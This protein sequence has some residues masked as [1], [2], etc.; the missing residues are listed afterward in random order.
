MRQQRNRTRGNGEGCIINLGSKRKN[1]W[2]ARVTVGYDKNGKQK[3]KY[4]GYYRT[5]TD[6]KKA[7]ANYLINPYNLEKLTTQDIFEK[8]V[9]TAK[10]TE[11][12]LKNYK[13]VIDKS[14][15]AKKVFKDI[16][17]MQLEEAA[18]EL[19]PA[20]QKRYRS[21]WKHL[22][23]YGMRHDLVNKNLADLIQI[24]KYVANKREAISPSNVK[25]ILSGDND[26]AKVLLYTGMR[27]GEL[28]DIKSKNV[29][30]ENRIMVGGLKTESGKNRRIPLSIEILPIIKKWLSSN[31]E[32][33]VTDE[34]GKKVNYNNYLTKVWHKDATLTKYSPHYTR[35]TWIS[36]A[37]KLELNQVIIKAIVGHSSSDVTSGVYTHIDD[38]QLLQTIDAFSY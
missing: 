10:F 23:E 7:L 17:L 9:E 20:M 36:R 34:K 25:K 8:W 16:S 33:L 15:L 5:K 12:V 32:Y 28:L 24:D 31:K 3:F 19:T 29:D 27:I 30:I 14:G 1:P 26:I 21:A 6:A 38:E 37:V 11:D 4:I 35:H 13:R 2:T 18:R 22:Y